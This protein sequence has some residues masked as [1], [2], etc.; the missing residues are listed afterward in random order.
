MLLRRDGVAF[1]HL[2]EGQDAVAVAGE[3]HLIDQLDPATREFDAGRGRFLAENLI[4]GLRSEKET[5]DG[6]ESKAVVR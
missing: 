3:R 1:R 5:G 4:A 6:G 2:H